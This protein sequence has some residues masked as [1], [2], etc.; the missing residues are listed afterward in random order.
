MTDQP[1]TLPPVPVHAV[2][3]HV[4]LAPGF[5]GLLAD[6]PEG[7]DTVPSMMSPRE[8][9]L[10]YNVADKYFTGRGVIIDAGLMCGASSML[11]GRAIQRR[12]GPRRRV[13]VAID[14]AIAEPGAVRF[15]IGHVPGETIRVGDSFAHVI[16]NFVEDVRDVVDLRIGDIEKVG[17]NI[18]KIVEILFLDVLKAQSVADFCM[19]T[20]FPLLSAGSFV[21]Q[22]DYFTDSLPWIREQQEHLFLTKRFSYIGEVGPTAIFLCRRRPTQESCI[23]AC[24]PFP[25]E[26]SALLLSAAEQRSN[27]PTR[28][29]L[30]GISRVWRA[31]ELRCVDEAAAVL[32]GVKGS[33]AALIDST[34]SKRVKNALEA[35]EFLCEEEWSAARAYRA[36][37]ISAGHGSGGASENGAATANMDLAAE[38]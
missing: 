23:E 34:R 27:D 24:G 1:P 20:Y 36:A 35:A 19:R 3:H 18:T 22:Q 21:L 2:M 37:L 7:V 11:F 9:K 17:A 5:E 8:R 4:S 29:L 16:E 31:A 15:I 26:H 13:I 6:L 32:R 14:R 12:P 38:S 28:R 33:Y 10:L 25:Y 30:C